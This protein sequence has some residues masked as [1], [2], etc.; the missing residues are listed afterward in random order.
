MFSYVERLRLY[1]KCSKLILKETAVRA[2]QS[3]ARLR[4]D[5]RRFVSRQVP[6]GRK[7]N[8]DVGLTLA[9]FCA[10]QSGSTPD[11]V[12]FITDAMK[13]FAPRPKKIILLALAGLLAGS[14]KR[15]PPAAA[16]PVPVYTAQVTQRPVPLIRN[17]VGLVQAG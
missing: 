13:P 15:H 17:A 5:S 7:F 1:L 12:L 16:A 8:Q 3:D 2:R 10:S 11:P 14:C 4:P 6:I 9:A